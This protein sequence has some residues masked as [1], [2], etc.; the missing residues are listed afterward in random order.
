[1]YMITNRRG[2]KTRR[3]IETYG[4][5]VYS[6][7]QSINWDS[8]HIN[9]EEDIKKIC[10]KVNNRSRYFSV[11]LKNVGKAEK[12][13]IEFRLANG[14]VNYD[15]WRENCLLFGRLI[16]TAKICSIDYSIK[17]EKLQK[18]FEPDLSEKEKLIRFLDLIFEDEKEKQ[19]F[20]KRWESRSGEKP[21]FGEKNVTTY[22]RQKKSEIKKIKEIE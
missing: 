17:K 1:M 16:Q 18:L 12:N 4:Q 7:I 21:L 8:V 6:K 2:E 11:N 9:N 13:T 20:Y 5:M 10:D 14:S 15:I 22:H 19:I 3:K